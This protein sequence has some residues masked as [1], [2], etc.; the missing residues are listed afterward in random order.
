M[1]KKTIIILLKIQAS[2]NQRIKILI[3]SDFSGYVLQ[4]LK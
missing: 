3:I 2:Q 4:S 1:Y